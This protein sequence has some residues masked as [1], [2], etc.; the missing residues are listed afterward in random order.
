MRMSKFLIFK[1]NGKKLGIKAGQV[2][3]IIKNV[4]LRDEEKEKL[5]SRIEIWGML[6][7]TINLHQLLHNS[8]TDVVNILLTEIVTEDQKKEIIG[9]TYDEIGDLAVLDD[10]VS[11]PFQFQAPTHHSYKEVIVNY[12]NES[13]TILNLCQLWKF[14]QGKYIFPAIYLAN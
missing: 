9:I 12:G 2:V 8:K 7:P 13:L 6:V 4:Q 3:N 1:V 14:C 11:Y 5:V 10:L